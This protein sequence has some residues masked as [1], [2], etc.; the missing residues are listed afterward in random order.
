RAVAVTALSGVVTTTNYPFSTFA[1]LPGT[2]YNSVNN[3][4][5]GTTCLK[6]GS[7]CP[8]STPANLTNQAGTDPAVWNTSYGFLDNG[9]PDWPALFVT[10]I[11]SNADNKA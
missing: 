2:T 7:P 5:V 9:R 3:P 8:I 10:D 4:T 1:P 6:D 11:T